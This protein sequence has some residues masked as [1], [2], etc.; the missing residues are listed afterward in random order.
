MSPVSF[1]NMER[2]S[3]AWKGGSKLCLFFILSAAFYLKLLVSPWSSTSFLPSL[4]IWQ[5]LVIFSYCA[6]TT[7]PLSCWRTGTSEKLN[8]LK[9]RSRNHST[10]ERSWAHL[11]K[12]KKNTPL[13]TRNAEC[14]VVNADDGCLD[15]RGITMR[16]AQ[17]SQEETER[18]ASELL[19]RNFN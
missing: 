18:K 17:H 13:K 4:V 19:L 8:E 2:W 1:Y 15:R 5:Y 10:W 3:I 9:K 7:H 12:K 14:K 11:L 16:R 6:R